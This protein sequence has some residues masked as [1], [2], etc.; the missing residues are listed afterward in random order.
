MRTHETPTQETCFPVSM[1]LDKKRDV[2]N[3]IVITFD[4]MIC[5][6][7]G[8]SINAHQVT[9]LPVSIVLWKF[10]LSMLPILA[11]HLIL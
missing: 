10:R 3:F 9:G 5:F 11:T 1:V 4:S 8:V 6:R 2:V 7:Q